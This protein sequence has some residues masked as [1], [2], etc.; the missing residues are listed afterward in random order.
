[1]ST[2]AS[3]SRRAAKAARKHEQQNA[4]VLPP[5]MWYAEDIIEFVEDHHKHCSDPR[6]DELGISL[7]ISG[8]KM[9]AMVLPHRLNEIFFATYGTGTNAD[10]KPFMALQLANPGGIRAMFDENGIPFGCRECGDHGDHDKPMCLAFTC[11]NQGAV[12]VAEPTVVKGDAD[13]SIKLGIVSIR[14]KTCHQPLRASGWP[15]Q[16]QLAP[17]PK[18]EY[19]NIYCS[20]HGIQPAYVTCVHVIDDYKALAYVDAAT[21]TESGTAVC[22]LCGGKMREG[23]VTIEELHMMCQAS[24]DLHLHGRLKALIENTGQSFYTL[25]AAS[26]TQST[27]SF[28]N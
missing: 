16:F 6:C 12:V 18:A 1:M 21:E 11:H 14:C 5:R 28:A 24:L 4:A 25:P 22:S 8:Q 9:I 19:P 3:R 20:R 13:T 26:D 27:L 23:G 10:Y 15:M 7:N 2:K 17:R